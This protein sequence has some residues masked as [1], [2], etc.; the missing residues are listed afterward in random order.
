MFY[1][2]VVGS[3][4]FDDYDLLEKTLDKLLVNQSAVTIVSGGAKGADTLAEEY[5]AEKGYEC[6][7]FKADWKQQGRAAGIIRNEQMHKYIAQYDKRGCVAFWDGQSRGTQSNFNL[8]KK[9]NNPLRIIYQQ[10]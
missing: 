1:C 9:Y 2:L 10:M 7:V 6:I 8:A 3:R 5:A 4:G